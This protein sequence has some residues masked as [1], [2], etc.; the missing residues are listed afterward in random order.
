MALIT[1]HVTTET[2]FHFG[3]AEKIS[4]FCQNVCDALTFLL[5][6]IFNSMYRQLVGIPMGTNSAPLVGD[7]FVF[8]YERDFRMSLSGDKQAYITDAFG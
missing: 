2:H 7:L 6:N 8:C 3:K 1:L 4:C 5:V